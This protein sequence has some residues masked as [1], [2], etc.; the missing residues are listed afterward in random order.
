MGKK[1]KPQQPLPKLLNYREVAEILGFSAQTIR[2]WVSAKEI[3]YI[4]I[5]TSVRFSPEMLEEMIEKAKRKKQ[6]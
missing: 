5:G 6:W 1:E 2:K 3:P 4:K